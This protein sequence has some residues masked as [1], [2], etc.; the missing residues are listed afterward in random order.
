MT[1]PHLI[2]IHKQWDW[3]M[4]GT[5]TPST[6]RIIFLIQGIWD[7]TLAYTPGNFASPHFGPPYETT[8]EMNH[9]CFKFFLQSFKVL[10]VLH[11]EK[12]WKLFIH[13]PSPA[14]FHVLF[15]FPFFLHIRGPP[16]SAWNYLRESKRSDKNSEIVTLTCT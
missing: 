13:F 8:P 12:Y 5:C 10:N 2:H 16:E 14:P 11:P 4:P 6:W 7:D 9:C 1:L 15:L 3:N